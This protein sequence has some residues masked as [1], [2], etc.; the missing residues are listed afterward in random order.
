MSGQ[1][2]AWNRCDRKRQLSRL[3]VMAHRL[4]A[5]AQENEHAGEAA[6]AAASGMFVFLG[7]ESWVCEP[8]SQISVTT[9]YCRLRIPLRS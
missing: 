4:N 8:K 1:L 3:W 2:N 5:P 6:D 9:L 7:E